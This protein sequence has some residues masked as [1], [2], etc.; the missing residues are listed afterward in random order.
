MSFRFREEPDSFTFVEEAATAMHRYRP[1]HT[2]YGDF[3]H[4]AFAPE[5]LCRTEVAEDG[6]PSIAILDAR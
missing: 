2:L 4:A 1:E 5:L 3:V 6:S